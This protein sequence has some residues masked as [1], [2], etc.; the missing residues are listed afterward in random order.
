MSSISGEWVLMGVAII[1]GVFMGG[2]MVL[3]EVCVGCY[4][5]LA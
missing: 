4:A 1:R 2:A 3:D 5:C